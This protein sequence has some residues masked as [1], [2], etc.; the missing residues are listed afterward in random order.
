MARAT[1]VTTLCIVVL[2]VGVA[3]C[4]HAEYITPDYREFTTGGVFLDKYWNTWRAAK[5]RL[6]GEFVRASSKVLG[7][8]FGASE[9]M[10]FYIKVPDGLQDV[11]VYAKPRFAQQIYEKKPG[12]RIVVYGT[13]LP[14]KSVSREDHG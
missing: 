7:G 1:A 10:V 12:Q 6:E 14:I 11:A 13:T 8:P 2:S 9:Q 4:G 5:V 3:S